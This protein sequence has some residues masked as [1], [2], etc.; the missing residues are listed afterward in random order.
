M[1]IEGRIDDI[2]ISGGENINTK[3]ITNALLKNPKIRDAFTFGIKDD[4]WGSAVV[5]AVVLND[6][7]FSEEN[8]K[9]FLKPEIASYKIPKRIFFVEEIPKTELGKIRK[10]ELLKQLNLY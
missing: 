5:S 7:S 6:K 9:E 4:K 3:E 1:F 10:E 2:I 8:L